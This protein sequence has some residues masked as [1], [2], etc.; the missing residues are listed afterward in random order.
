M[1]GISANNPAAVVTNASAISGATIENSN[2][3]NGS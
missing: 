2:L 3:L 1:A